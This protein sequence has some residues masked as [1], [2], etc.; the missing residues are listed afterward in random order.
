MNWK[1][2]DEYI[3]FQGRAVSHSLSLD[4]AL[5][6]VISVRPDD[7]YDNKLEGRLVHIAGQLITGEPLTEPDYGIQVLAVKLRRRVQMY[8][9]IEDEM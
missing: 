3:Y 9:W 4:E 6:N 5:E 7:L 1:T 8:Q 2:S